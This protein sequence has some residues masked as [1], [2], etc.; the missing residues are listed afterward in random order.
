M[1]KRGR[2]RTVFAVRAGLCAP[3][4]PAMAVWRAGTIQS[5]RPAVGIYPEAKK[6]R[7]HRYNYLC[8]RSF[9]ASK[10]PA[11]REPGR[12]LQCGAPAESSSLGRCE[13]P[14]RASFRP[15][16]N[17]LQSA[18]LLRDGEGLLVGDDHHVRVELEYGGGN[19]RSN[20]AE[21]GV[22]DGLGLAP[23]GG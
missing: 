5:A 4:A 15:L 18:F 16:R 20:R 19:L 2:C 22:V 14:C 23:A 10:V 3:A 1:Q 11:A 17:S 9:F 12:A 6:E 21:A 7:G 8:P 13:T